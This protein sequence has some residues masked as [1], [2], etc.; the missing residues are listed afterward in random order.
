[1]M[2]KRN[3]LF[4]LAVIVLIVSISGCTTQSDTTKTS[5]DNQTNEQVQQNKT[6]SDM[7][8][9]QSEKWER[10]EEGTPL[11]DEDISATIETEGK[12]YFVDS[13]SYTKLIKYFGTGGTSKP[14]YAKIE[15]RKVLLNP[16]A[17]VIVAVF[18]MN[19]DP[20]P[21]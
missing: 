6:T 1:M 8:Y 7:V 11:Y 16:D 4:L 15:T 21:S 5:S 3:Y 13:Q 18:D 2:K 19:G 17:K 9:I 14:F 12:D 10:V 20:L